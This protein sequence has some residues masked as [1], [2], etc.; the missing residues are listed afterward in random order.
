MASVNQREWRIPGKRTKRLAWGFSV[1]V[2]GKRTKKYCAEWSKEDAEKELA[3]V[4]L[5][6]EQEQRSEQPGITL[7]DAVERYFAAKVRKKSVKD[8]ERH[9]RMFL[10][11]FGSSLPLAEV[12]SAR[13]NAWKSERLA[14]ICPQTRE[15]YAAA[16]INRPLA[17]LRHMLRLAQEEGRLTAVPRIRLE[18]EPQG[19]LRWLTQ[20]EIA[21]LLAACS[22]SRNPELQ[23]AVIIALNTG[24][25]RAE[26]LE[27][28]WDRVDLS[29]SV[30][31][32]EVTKSG[33]RR[34][35]PINDACYRALSTLQP[36]EG[37]RVFRT[38]TIRTAY[39]NAVE[40]AKLDDVTFHTLRHTFASWAMMK[41]ATLRELQELLGHSS[42][43]MTMRYAHLSPEHLRSAVSRLDGLTVTSPAEVLPNRAQARAH[44]VESLGVVLR[45]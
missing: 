23:A 36:K 30:I 32:L 45:N 27:L 16:S 22:K 33:R 1:T 38:R 26:L 44:E 24:L 15:P 29:R 20:E 39:E 18:K 6:L 34:E 19:R 5:G 13:I 10:T 9:L 4:M 42:L 14:A 40:A 41:G 28:T 21:R 31:R 43:T 8:D 7:G 11:A 2:N 12:T 37:G 35:V 17:A 25:R 3:T